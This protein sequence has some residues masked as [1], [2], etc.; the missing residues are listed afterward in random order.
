MRSRDRLTSLPLASGLRGER[1]TIHRNLCLCLLV[2]ELLLLFGLDATANAGACV[3]VAVL[4]HF[5][6]LSAFSWMLVEGIQVYQQN[7]TGFTNR[8]SLSAV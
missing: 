1:T 6:F 5:F 2:A 7:A 8:P 3:A 4:M